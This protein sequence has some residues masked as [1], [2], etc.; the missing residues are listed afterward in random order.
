[1]TVAVLVGRAIVVAGR[2]I[3]M[4]RIQIAFESRSAA[5][6]EC[7]AELT[8]EWFAPSTPSHDGEIYAAAS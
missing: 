3:Q 1:M 5:A 4:V 2:L 7:L 8:E 6:G